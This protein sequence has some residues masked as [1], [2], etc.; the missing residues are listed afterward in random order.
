MTKWDIDK[1][2]KWFDSNIPDYKLVSDEYIDQYHKLNILCP[3]GHLYKKRW[4]QVLRGE[5]CNICSMSSG[6]QRIYNHLNKLM[7]SFES[8]YKFPDCRNEKELPFDF[9]VFANDKLFC[10]IEFDGQQHFQ[11]RG[12]GRETEEEILLNFKKIKENDSIKNQYCKSN[13]IKLVRIPYW[14][15]H[16]IEKILDK[17]LKEVI[18]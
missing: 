12:F 18:Q 5:L 1:V 17:E 10:L 6:A 3:K 8:E 2:R 4:N 16:D 9:A 15:G 7:F 11:P 14:K 13:K